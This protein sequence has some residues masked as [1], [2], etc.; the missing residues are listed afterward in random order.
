MEA[1]EGQD[2]MCALPPSL[3]PCLPACLPDLSIRF[4]E[5]EMVSLSLSLSQ[6]QSGCGPGCRDHRSSPISHTAFYSQLSGLVV[7]VGPKYIM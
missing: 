1:G 4:D 3:P 6:H 5:S 2:T 7:R